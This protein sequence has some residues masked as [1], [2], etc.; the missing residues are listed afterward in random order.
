V[1]RAGSALGGRGGND[2]DVPAE[3]QH[4]TGQLSIAKSLPAIKQFIADGGT[5]I[6]MG[7]SSALGFEM[8]LPIQNHLLVRTPGQPDRPLT[9]E[10]FYI[11][12]SVL[13]VAVDSTQAG[14][15]GF[16]STLDVFFNN[17]PVF[18]LEPDAASKGVKPLAWFDSTTPLRSGWAWGQNYL[19]GGAAAVEADIGK[20]KLYLFGPEI[21]FRGET[22]GTFKF[23]FNGIYAPSNTPAV[24]P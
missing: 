2:D 12:G 5:V 11:P 16:G 15:A 8:G 10:E 20:G 1:L 23:L 13:Q 21:T 18:R 7:S 22:H 6:T 9:G 3:F 4:M 24:V 17:S 14:A 19:Q